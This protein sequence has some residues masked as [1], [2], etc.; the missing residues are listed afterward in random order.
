MKRIMKLL[1]IGLTT[2]VMAATAEDVRP[3]MIGQLIPDVGLKT[4]EGK[5][6]DLRAA[7]QEQPLVLIFYRGGWCPFCNKHLGQL[8]QV[9]P[10]LR[11]LGYRI[12]AVSPDRPEKLSGAAEKGGLSYTLVSDSSMAAAKAF[13]IAFK[14][15]DA[16]LEKYAGYGIDL[17]AA[18]GETHHLLPVPAVFIVGKDGAIDFSYANPDYKTRLAS[19]VLLA[20]A[21]A[22]L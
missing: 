11:E 12:V 5:A 14:V 19:E 7:A 22:A 3:L 15:D 8:Q 17:E 20:A 1:V 13:G 4:A 9:D 18:S 2:T 21:K 6:F 10:Q 16:T